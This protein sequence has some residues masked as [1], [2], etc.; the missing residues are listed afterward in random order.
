M[1]RVSDDHSLTGHLNLFLSPSPS[2]FSLLPLYAPHSFHHDLHLTLCFLSV[3][4]SFLI[5][6]HF[7]NRTFAAL[8]DDWSLCIW[9]QNHI[10]GLIQSPVLTGSVQ[11]WN[12]QSVYPKSTEQ[13]PRYCMIQQEQPMHG[14]NQWC[15]LL[16]F[17][18]HGLWQCQKHLNM[19]MRQC[20][21]KYAP[22]SIH[23]LNRNLNIGLSHLPKSCMILLTD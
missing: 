23:F 11:G 19:Q 3:T 14:Q 16:C 9:I 15:R 17:T 7:S 21:I 2:L 8:C 6:S 1:K 18:G 5:L 4:L 10:L 12:H 22:I 20:L 13:S